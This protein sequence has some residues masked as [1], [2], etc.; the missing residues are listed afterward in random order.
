MYSVHV[1]TQYL[2]HTLHTLFE[3]FWGISLYVTD[4]ATAK[5]FVMKSL[6]KMSEIIDVHAYLHVT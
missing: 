6:V 3:K 1:L 5:L 4:N 2:Q